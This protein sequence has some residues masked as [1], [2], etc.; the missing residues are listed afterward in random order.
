MPF[1]STSFS[2][3]ASAVPRKGAMPEAMEMP[4]PVTNTGWASTKCSS[5]RRRLS[6]VMI[7]PKC[8]VAHQEAPDGAHRDGRDVG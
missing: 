1:S 5:S 3:T 4:A 2:H 6:G 7:V 8:P